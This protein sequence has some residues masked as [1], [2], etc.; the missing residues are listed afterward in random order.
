MIPNLHTRADDVVSLTVCLLPLPPSLPGN[1][2]IEEVRLIALSREA[3][4]S[5]SLSL[6]LSEI[7]VPLKGRERGTEQQKQQRLVT[8]RR[9]TTYTHQCCPGPVNR[10]ST[11]S[12]HWLK[13]NL[14]LT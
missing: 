14:D 6:S 3:D 13:E 5:L 9:Y 11:A 12:V 7:A 1:W 4:L 10:N 2:K 8:G